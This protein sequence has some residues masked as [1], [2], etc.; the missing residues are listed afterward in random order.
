MDHPAKPEK[1]TRTQQPQSTACS[2]FPVLSS[3]TFSVCSSAAENAQSLLM[4]VLS[5][6]LLFSLFLACICG[7]FANAA[8]EAGKLEGK[9]EADD[10]EG[11]EEESEAGGDEEEA[12]G[13]EG[14]EEGLE[15]GALD[16]REREEE[17]EE[18]GDAGA[19]AP[20][21]PNNDEAN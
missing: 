2:L 16:A 4:N 11:R 6:P 3:W 13:E 9:A 14:G 8:N 12:A 20:P 17:E 15:D 19:P 21:P 10:A 5:S 7:L 18:E 1:Q